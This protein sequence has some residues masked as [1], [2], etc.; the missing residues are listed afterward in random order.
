[1]NERERLLRI[2]KLQEVDR[3]PCICPMQTGTIDL[4]RAS[5]AFWPEAHHDPE[6]MASLALAA[7]KFAGLE[8]VRV[9]FEVSVDASAFG[10]QTKDRAL[11]RR[12]LIL[13]KTIKGREGFEDVELPDPQKDGMV[14]VV[15]EA[16]KLIRRRAPT[17][18]LIC[19][20]VAPHMLA[21]ELLGEQ[22]AT[23]LMNEDPV[24][25]RATLQKAKLWA[26]THATA[27]AD[28]GAD[29]IAL[30]DAYASADFLPPERYREYALPFHRKVCFELEKLD[31]P[32]ILH[33]CGNASPNLP[34]MAETGACGISV[35]HQVDIREA[36]RLL[37]GKSA[38]I[39]NISPSE[40]LLRGSTEQVAAKTEECIDKG[41]D[42]VSPGCG[43]VLETPLQNLRAMVEATKRFGSRPPIGR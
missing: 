13:E 11:G 5:G 33:I 43:L 23:S 21:I 27:A 41:I 10:A 3:V 17:L 1:V 20:V 36:K 34:L 28:A 29:V 30:V 39:G 12:P 7:N 35:D 9:P 25:F 38:V 6:K 24:L 4:M 40:I 18:P 15:L 19:G 14:P 37:S 22:E 8:S 42:A 31:V 16:M 32:V 26:I 2:L